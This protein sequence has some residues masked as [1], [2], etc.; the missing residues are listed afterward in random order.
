MKIADGRILTGEQAKALGLVDALGNL[1]D[2]V[3]E[4]GRMG[5]ISGEPKVVTP[6][7]MRSPARSSG[8][9]CAPCSTVAGERSGSFKLICRR[10]GGIMGNTMSDL[11]EKLSIVDQSHKKECEVIVDTVFHNMKTPSSGVRRS[12]SAAMILHVRV[13]RGEEGRNPKRGRCPSPRSGIPFSS[14]QGTPGNG[15]RVR[16]KDGPRVLPWGGRIHTAVVRGRRRKKRVIFCAG[17]RHGRPTASSRGLP[18][19]RRPPELLTLQQR[20]VLVPPAGTGRPL[21][22]PGRAAELFSLVP[23]DRG[24]SGRPTARWVRTW[25]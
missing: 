23:S 14:R 21:R 5:G 8:R 12:R 1:E 19:L 25:G 24:D 9:R 3:A 18:P 6:P 16:G 17:G 11:V 10:R 13:R 20:A 15:Q 4:A 7:K 2:T 22:P